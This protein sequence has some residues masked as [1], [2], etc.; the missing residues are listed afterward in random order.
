MS[1]PSKPLPPALRIA[2]A[3]RAIVVVLALGMLFFGCRLYNL[4]KKLSPENAEFLST[5]RYII[6][7]SERRVFLQLPDT[8]KAAFIADFWER[9]NPEPGRSENE[10]KT[11][12]FQRID[13]ANR[14]LTSGKPGWL[15]D[16][17]K[18]FI[19]LG[20]PVRKSYYSHMN[21]LDSMSPPLEVWQY[22]DFS[23]LFIDRLNINDW[24]L[25]Y[26]NLEHQMT[27]NEALIKAGHNTLRS[28]L[29]NGGI[30][31][32]ELLFRRAG[33]ANYLLVRIDKKCLPFR[34]QGDD[35]VA[36]VD[37]RVEIF[38][39]QGKSVW[40]QEQ[41]HPQSIAK[42]YSEKDLQGQFTITIEL[43][44]PPGHYLGEA[45]LNHLVNDKSL[46]K[47]LNFKII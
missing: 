35:Y 9:R 46:A 20:E 3:H 28:D 22:P 47:K 30:M 2:N 6:S 36:E 12:Y 41:T 25:Y 10:F 15:T 11:Q 23:V 17:G 34:V 8:E 29:E 37:L 18:V 24:E 14:L 7:D 4:E 27:V 31:D 26:I 43:N 1:Q 33:M 19:L 39:A 5:V 38:D 42:T 40:Q 16:R 13:E 32:F 21:T 44:L 45:Q